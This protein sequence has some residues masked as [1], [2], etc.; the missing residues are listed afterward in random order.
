[1]HYPAATTRT[2]K[3]PSMPRLNELPACRV[4][5]RATSLLAAV[6][7]YS[8][9]PMLVLADEDNPATHT[10]HDP[11]STTAAAFDPAT[12]GPDRPLPERPALRGTLANGV[13]YVIEHQ[14]VADNDDKAAVSVLIQ[15]GSLYETPDQA[16]HAHFI[17]HI[18][19]RGSKGQSARKTERFLARMGVPLAL[20]GQQG[21][22]SLDATRFGMPIPENPS[23][24]VPTALKI[25]AKR[26]SAPLFN[27]DYIAAERDIV[28]A[29]EQQSRSSDASDRR[30][31]AVFGASHPLVTKR[32]IGTRESLKAATRDSLHHFY[33][34]WYRP[35]RMIVVAVGD[36]D[37]TAIERAIIRHFGSIASA[38]TP[39]PPNRSIGPPAGF[40]AAIIEDPNLKVRSVSLS[41]MRHWEPQPTLRQSHKIIALGFSKVV[42]NNKLN[43]Y[44]NERGY[45]TTVNF[46]GGSSFKMASDDVGVATEDSHLL[47]AFTEV[48]GI[49]TDV[50][51]NGIT[52]AELETVR[53][54]FM[55]GY[56]S[57][58]ER[59][60]R[61]RNGGIAGRWL[62]MLNRDQ[63]VVDE[64]AGIN[65]GRFL[66]SAITVDEVK[67]TFA[68]NFDPVRTSL[69]LN[70]P[71]GEQPAEPIERFIAIANHIP[72]AAKMVAA[73]VP[74]TGERK[75][76]A[77]PTAIDDP[78]TIAITTPGTITA[79]TSL[80]AFETTVWRLSNGAHVL[81]KPNPEEN[82]NVTLELRSPG[83]LSLLPDSDIVRS[84]IARDVLFA[85]GIR[86]VRGSDL[87]N[88]FNLHRTTGSVFMGET[89]HGVVVQTQ[90]D[91]LDFG[92]RVLRLMATEG[93]VDPTIFN[94]QMAKHRTLIEAA[95]E[96]P[97]FQYASEVTERIWP[98][99][100]TN[101]SN[102][103]V[104]MLN[105]LS[106][107]W[108]E[109][110]YALMFES[111]RGSYFLITGP[112]AKNDV[113]PFVEQYLATLP[114]G[115][116][117]PKLNTDYPHAT[118]SS[119][120]RRDTNPDDRS[121][122]AMYFIE[123]T[124]GFDDRQSYIRT[125]YARLL[126]ERLLNDIRE[127][128]GLVYSITAGAVSPRYPYPHGLV[129]VSF[130]SDP[131]NVAEIEERVLTA[132][133]TVGR[134]VTRKSLRP[135]RQQMLR[136]FNDSLDKPAR[137]LDALH[138]TL[139]QN[140]PVPTPQEIVEVI[141]SLNRKEVMAF[142]RKVRDKFVVVRTEHRPAAKALSAL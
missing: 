23:R 31:E 115:N 98:G 46:G 25:L 119:E 97:R 27:D 47:A 26:V 77:A 89:S 95:L 87:S 105:D 57:R 112:V 125:A 34:T 54:I 43:D 60:K 141:E 73:N 30:L 55:Q 8:L 76:A 42:L 128:R 100:K 3:E 118:T 74:E 12:W 19:F 108:I 72:A 111:F 18:L 123:P 56:R 62:A 50:I 7:V 106:G 120:V 86:G 44:R 64:L 88:R 35:D 6:L 96:N 113:R 85:S 68:Q 121:V 13:R 37:P 129:T 103:T 21:T 137:I 69:I 2:L 131:S 63:I 101:M 71:E 36:F 29:E 17:E 142:A 4:N 114:T 90:P 11:A 133:D 20:H 75:T 9:S 126:T 109:E 124:P 102:L 136:R 139:I 94:A 127:D 79:E 93:A 16:G 99:R 84:R 67:A 65:A 91:E 51:T 138:S 81:F 33:T 92:F 122:N 58:E 53:G 10:P 80:D 130:V 48:T 59:H 135:I 134:K 45:V 41:F 116:P 66:T 15:T 14:A 40:N 38:T 1:L 78:F 28:L 82:T 83:G 5:R 107:A 24:N 52:N 22:T 132:M 39:N 104:A 61:N 70:M 49:I 110:A 140:E 117:A 32:P